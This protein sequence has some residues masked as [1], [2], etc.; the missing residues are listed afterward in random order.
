MYRITLDPIDPSIARVYRRLH[1]A[2][3]F[4]PVAVVA[5]DED[6]KLRAEAAASRAVFLA[7]LARLLGYG[8]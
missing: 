3:A 6:M 2:I 7:W 4:Y 8:A 5:M 1:P